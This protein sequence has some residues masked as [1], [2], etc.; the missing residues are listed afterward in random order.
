METL[1]ESI[2]PFIRANREKILLFIGDFQRSRS[3]CRLDQLIKFFI[4]QSNLP[5]NMRDY[6]TRQSHAIHCEVGKHEN[7]ELRRVA[8]T[9]WIHRKA[10]EHRSRSMIQQVFCFE[11]CKEMLLPLIEEELGLTIGAGV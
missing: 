11:K 10:E 6:M 7:A 2:L 9:E 4:I 1:K 5:F 8:V 3:S